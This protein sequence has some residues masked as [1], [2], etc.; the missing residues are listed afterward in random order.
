MDNS[1]YDL[2]YIIEMGEK[3][4]EIY[5]SAYQMI[6]GRLTNIILIYSAIGIYLISIIQDVIDG[7]NIFY[8]LI[9]GLFL[10]MTIMS[11]NYTIR[12]LIPVN[13]A[14]LEISKRY[15]QDLRKDYE[16]KFIKSEMTEEQL[17]LAQKKVD[18]YL[19]ASYIDELTQAQETNQTV[20]IEKSSLYYRALI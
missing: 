7:A 14:Y 8:L 18:T 2:D 15:S 11:V 3:R 5:T 13:V 10:I 6:L 9:A 12:L 17:K 1:F 20:F 4:V 16:A 19:K